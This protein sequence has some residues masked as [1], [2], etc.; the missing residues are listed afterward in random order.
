MASEEP[1]KK[2]LGD[3]FNKIAKAATEAFKGLGDAMEGPVEQ[4]Q[5]FEQ[6]APKRRR[7]KKDPQRFQL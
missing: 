5:P 2:G 6:P 7:I 4:R 1:K 3:F